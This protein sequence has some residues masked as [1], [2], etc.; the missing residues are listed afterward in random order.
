M[1]QE[2]AKEICKLD[3]WTMHTNRGH[4]AEIV[5]EL[6][7]KR[8]KSR[9]IG[10]LGSFSTLA[11]SLQLPPFPNHFYDC[12]RLLWC[13]GEPVGNN[14]KAI[15]LYSVAFALNFNLALN[16]HKY[17]LLPFHQCRTHWP[18][19]RLRRCGSVN[20]TH[21]HK[22][23]VGN[24]TKTKWKNPKWN[25]ANLKHN[26]KYYSVRIWII[27]KIRS[28]YNLTFACFKVMRLKAWGFATEMNLKVEN[29]TMCKLV[30]MEVAIFPPQNTWSKNV[31]KFCK[32]R[33]R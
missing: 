9:R 1:L 22:N 26:M 2:V 13:G 19:L 16:P 23:R 18:S 6:G 30:E 8:G 3:V 24:E 21:A 27:R 7:W 5:T 17:F 33:S 15:G 11:D 32:K 25:D 20:S 28:N 29:A 10:M 12:Q 14:R 31:P 4:S